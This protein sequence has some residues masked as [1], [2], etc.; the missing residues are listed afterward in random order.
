[1]NAHE[2]GTGAECVRPARGSVPGRLS[3]SDAVV[4]SLL[5]AV[6][7]SGCGGGGSGGPGAQT[8]TPPPSGDDQPGFE[9]T[10]DSAREAAG[11][12]LALVL[13][14]HSEA[15]LAVAVTE[16]LASFV[17]VGLGAADMIFECGPEDLGA[18]PK[19]DWQDDDANRR[20]SN[21]DTVTLS[22]GTCGGQ[23]AGS[24]ELTI[25][26][27]AEDEL[28]VA[29]LRGRLTFSRSLAPEGLPASSTDGSLLLD[30][31]APEGRTN[32]LLSEIELTNESAEVSLRLRDSTH[33]LTFDHTKQTRSVSLGGSVE[34]VATGNEFHFDMPVAFE[35]DWRAHPALGELVVDSG[36]SRARLTTLADTR[37]RAWVALG[38]DSDASGNYEEQAELRWDDLLGGDAELVFRELFGFVGVVRGFF[39][40]PFGPD[41]EQQLG[42]VT[43]IPKKDLPRTGTYHWEWYRN[44][45]LEQ[46]EYPEGI[47]SSVQFLVT[48]TPHLLGFSRAKGDVI[49]AK[50]VFSDAPDATRIASAVIRN[51]PPDMGVSLSP[52]EAITT[53]D[54]VAN[55]EEPTDID[56]DPVVLSREWRVNDLVVEGQTGNRLAAEHHLRGDQVTF[57]VVADDGE[58]VAEFSAMTVIGDAAPQVSGEAPPT[59]EHGGEVSFEVAVKDADGDPIPPGTLRV[60]YGPPGMEVDQDGR[61][62]LRAAMPLFDRSMD[63]HWQIS[64]TDASTVPLRGT[65]GV[66]E[67]DGDYPWFRTRLQP[68]V[69]MYADDF[70]GDGDEEVLVLGQAGPHVLEWDGDEYAQSWAYPYP[71]S[72]GDFTSMAHADIDQDG[73]QEIFVAAGGD[74]AML[75]GRER[76]MAATGNLPQLDDGDSDCH[77]MDV[78]D[79]DGDGLWELV[80]LTSS[81][82]LIVLSARDLEVLWVEGPASPQFSFSGGFV[83][84]GVA[85][86]NVDADPALEIVTST[87]YVYDGASRSLD[88][89]HERPFSKRTV[90]LS[91]LDGDGTQEIIGNL[92]YS[93]GKGQLPFPA[94]SEH[95]PERAQGTVA[96]TNGDGKPELVW[97]N[98]QV[99]ML[100]QVYQYDSLESDPELLFEVPLWPTVFSDHQIRY[101][102]S[103]EWDLNHIAAGDVDG[104][105][106]DELVFTGLTYYAVVGFQG[107]VEFEWLATDIKPSDFRGGVLDWG[108]PLSLLFITQNGEPHF[109]DDCDCGQAV[110]RFP[111]PQRG[112]NT[113]ART[114]IQPTG[115]AEM[116]KNGTITDIVAT[117]VNDDGAVE[118]IVALL[119]PEANYVESD[120]GASLH[121]FDSGLNKWAVLPGFERLSQGR[122]TPWRLALGDVNGDGRVDLLAGGSFGFEQPSREPYV[123]AFDLLDN[124]ILFETDDV[125]DHE[126]EYRASAIAGADLDG[127]G[128]AE[129]V[130]GAEDRLKRRHR[131]DRLLVYAQSGTDGEFVRTDHTVD[132]EKIHDIFVRDFDGDGAPEVLLLGGRAYGTPLT[133]VRLNAEFEELDRFSLE[134]GPYFYKRLF[135]PDVGIDQVGRRTVLFVE[136]GGGISDWPLDGSIVSGIDVL[137]GNKV[138]TSPVTC[139]G[140]YA[141]STSS[142]MVSGFVGLLPPQA[143]YT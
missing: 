75:D 60:D 4:V 102:D 132:L 126:N 99:E 21:G 34:N 134:N 47:F 129:I 67:R 111:I 37:R 90:T 41:R 2:C 53:D 11:V 119:G 64:S 121:V 65:T 72:P 22:G 80:C 10:V 128:R 81:N 6:M 107:G 125:L 101:P 142:A 105:G 100:V 124:T 71:I 140:R 23:T 35:Q 44:G 29:E 52:D 135:A 92:V 40:R 68:P 32:V 84:T 45:Q 24:T 20:I 88:W 139:W 109:L 97:W 74:L 36:R 96:D 114:T 39:V 143:V 12:A 118:L 58:D 57:S 95:Y 115:G 19:V 137:T 89:K 106:W 133:V 33:R 16:G 112:T 54:I 136:S 120:P 26:G 7:M 27:Y 110:M 50:L 28:G 138:W 13:N 42:T 86:G 8:P 25:T 79:L 43:H 49:E 91:D 141:I 14:A 5:L 104:D 17:A 78:G 69:K 1:M 48:R 56:G 83:G 85:V 59:V 131:A 87:G 9:L 108:M 66:V 127:D 76:R 93:T 73:F 77:D 62:T 18:P 70:D 113:L 46:S 30:Y 38:L 98:G 82:H 117:D 130:V 123:V 55:L 94:Q 31:A 61:V 116:S 51:S 3:S 63:L 103:D 15:E 122:R